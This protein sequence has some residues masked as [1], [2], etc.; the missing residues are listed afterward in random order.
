V[1]KQQI[2][3]KKRKA[4]KIEGERAIKEAFAEIDGMGGRTQR[5]GGS[6]PAQAHC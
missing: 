1:L 4:G 5:N 6:R 2:E 3:E